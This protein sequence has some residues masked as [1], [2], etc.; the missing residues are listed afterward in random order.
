MFVFLQVSLKALK[1]F[2]AFTERFCSK[3]FAILVTYR[4]AIFQSLQVC[5]SLC[6]ISHI[7]RTHVLSVPEL[8]KQHV[9]HILF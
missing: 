6:V 3:S 7:H 4:E 1:P 8:R 5:V 9:M 2:A